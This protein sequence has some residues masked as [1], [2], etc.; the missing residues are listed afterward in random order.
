MAVFLKHRIVIRSY[1]ASSH[2]IICY[3]L[4]SWNSYKL[5]KNSISTSQRTQPVTILETNQAKL[6]RGKI[7]IYFENDTKRMQRRHKEVRMFKQVL[8]RV[9]KLIKWSIFANKLRGWGQIVTCK[10]SQSLPQYKCKN[11]SSPYAQLSIIAWRYIGG[12]E[13]QLYKFLTTALELDGGGWSILQSNRF[14]P[15]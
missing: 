11:A 3:P 10:R 2:L 14:T 4:E 6:F 13:V 1:P 5:R 9:A 15:R 8:H 12:V 7:G